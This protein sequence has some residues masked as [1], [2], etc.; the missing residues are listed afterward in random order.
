MI[1]LIRNV[2]Y[3][4]RKLG[5]HLTKESGYT[6]QFT[7]PEVLWRKKRIRLRDVTLLRTPE[8][9]SETKSAAVD[10]KVATI[11]V[12]LSLLRWA[13]GIEHTIIK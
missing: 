13:T 1:I 3:I 9:A 2:G 4:A 11:D 5:D 7:S 12:R 6:F 10:L 8:T